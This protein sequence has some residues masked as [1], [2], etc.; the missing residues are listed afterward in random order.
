MVMA[1]IIIAILLFF[2]FSLPVGATVSPPEWRVWQL[3]I[4][5]IREV[6]GGWFVN[7]NFTVEK[8]D[9]DSP[10]EQFLA[11]R[12]REHWW[13]T[14]TPSSPLATKV[15]AVVD[16]RGQE[17]RIIN[18]LW[19]YLAVYTG[20]V[21]ENSNNKNGL[22]SEA[23]K[24]K[25]A[26]T[27]L[28]RTQGGG[29]EEQFSG[30]FIGSQGTVLSTAHGLNAKSAVWVFT[31]DGKEH[32]ARLIKMDK[33]ADLAILQT[34]VVPTIFVSLENATFVQ[35]RDEL[36]FAIGNPLDVQGVIATGSVYGG[37][38]MINNVPLWQ[39]EMSVYPGSSGGPVFNDCGKLV[40]VVKGRHRTIP[41]ITFMIPIETVDYFLRGKQ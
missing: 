21:D 23:V 26:A 40:G 19:E 14:L 16:V 8:L 18:K 29:N 7:K 11:T 34:N 3:P 1:R 4:V 9:S 36:L 22:A 17:Q 32:P 25:I 15:T 20:T 5:E 13:L 31:A 27:V 6:I 24:R 30:F 38:R 37:L 12:G 10:H 41:D 35:H 28:L 39:L 33:T 2:T